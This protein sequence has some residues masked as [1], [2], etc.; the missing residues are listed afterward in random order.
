MKNIVLIGMP[1]SGKTTFSMALAEKLRRPFVD[2][3][4][5]LEEKEGRT[6]QSFFAESEKTFRDAEERTIEDLSRRQN[7]IIA[8]GGG[9]VK[10][11]RNVARLHE[12]GLLIFID[13][14]AEDI[15]TDVEVEKRPLL[16]EGPDKV[17]ALY[18]E[19]IALY[20]KAADRILENRGSEEEVLA[21]LLEM[22]GGIEGRR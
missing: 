14:R 16:A 19:R 7:L 4:A 1:G 20:R 15:V 13:R 12:T 17:F 2:A 5:Y 6:I 11:S 21:R 10:R 22:V 9:V 8:T 18:K 3:D